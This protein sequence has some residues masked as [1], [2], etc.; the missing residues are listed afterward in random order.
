M[1]TSWGRDVILWNGGLPPKEST[2]DEIANEVFP[3]L[4]RAAFQFW[5]N[6]IVKKLALHIEVDAALLSRLEESS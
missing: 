4:R 1:R 3:E 6:D 2:Q 5:V